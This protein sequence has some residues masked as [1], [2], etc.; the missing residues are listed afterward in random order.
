MPAAAQQAAVEYKNAR[1]VD[2]AGVGVV[3]ARGGDEVNPLRCFLPV[4][5]LRGGRDRVAF[6]PAFSGL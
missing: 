3:L 5:S 6:R 4:G 2:R 1:P